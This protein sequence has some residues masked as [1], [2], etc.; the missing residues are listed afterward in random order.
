VLDI[1]HPLLPSSVPV[2]KDGVHGQK[3]RKKWGGA[4]KELSD[5]LLFT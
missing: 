2:K 1:L 5:A 3:K 4:K